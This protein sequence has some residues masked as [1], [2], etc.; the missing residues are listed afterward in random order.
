MDQPFFIAIPAL[1]FV[2]LSLEIINIIES[3]MIHNEIN[4][5]EKITVSWRGLNLQRFAPDV[6]LVPTLNRL[7]H[8]LATTSPSP[9]HDIPTNSC[10]TMSN[11]TDNQP[12]LQCLMSNYP[13]KGSRAPYNHKLYL[14]HPYYYVHYPHI[15]QIR[16]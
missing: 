6:S 9:H 12:T 1:W 14:L 4:G 7:N 10:T 13:L 5:T 2:G 3:E 8:E 16:M 11:G 15:H